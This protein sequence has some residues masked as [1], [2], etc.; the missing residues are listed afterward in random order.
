M[1]ALS[2]HPDDTPVPTARTALLAG[3]LK[4]LNF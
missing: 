1:H 2:C 4:L 3:G